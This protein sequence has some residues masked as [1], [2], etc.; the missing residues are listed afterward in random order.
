MAVVC[1][2]GWTV[3]T[4]F[5]TLAICAA[6]AWFAP[7]FDAL[8]VAYCLLN[9]MAIL[10]L[11]RKGFLRRKLFFAIGTLC[12]TQ[13]AYSSIRLGTGWFIYDGKLLLNLLLVVFL[14]CLWTA[15]VLFTL[16]YFNVLV[17]TARATNPG[18]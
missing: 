7:L 2:A 5:R 12:L 15:G 10:L 3:R 9:I 18:N 6:P 16:K 4:E 1:P 13:A 14:S 17:P 8:G 11:H